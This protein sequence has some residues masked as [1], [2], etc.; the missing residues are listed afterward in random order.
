MNV[1]DVRFS[2]FH[3]ALI[4]LLVTGHAADSSR[5]RTNDHALAIVCMKVPQLNNAV[6]RRTPYTY[7]T[8]EPA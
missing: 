6:V 2:K 1:W 4:P 3:L 8:L 5:T 7:H